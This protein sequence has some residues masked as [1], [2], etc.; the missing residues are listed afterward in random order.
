MAVTGLLYTYSFNGPRSQGVVSKNRG[1]N[2]IVNA[3]SGMPQKFGSSAGGTT[4]SNMRRLYRN[5][6]FLS[7]DNRDYNN[8]HKLSN[9]R[10]SGSNDS[11]QYIQS[12]KAR[13][14]GKSSM[15]AN[16]VS[17]QGQATPADSYRNSALARV[18][19]GGSVAPK[20]KGSI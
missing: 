4:F 3:T 2:A 10:L 19:G 5:N 1:N 14:V 17:F 9:G 7:N 11:S 12:R 16:T 18:R 20:K 13:A 8:E 6:L 15:I